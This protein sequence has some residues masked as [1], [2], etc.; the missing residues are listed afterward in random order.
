MRLLIYIY[1][2]VLDF[3]ITREF[4]NKINLFVLLFLSTIFA[5]GQT[6]TELSTQTKQTSSQTTISLQVPHRTC[7]SVDVLNQQL[8]ADPNLQQRRDAIEQQTAAYIA[9][10]PQSA[11][12][13]VI[14]IPVV[15]HVI[16]DGD[17]VGSN[18]NISIAAIMAQLDQL[19]EDFRKLNSDVGNVPS[20]FTSLVA[21]AEIEFCLAQRDP[22]GNATSGIM[23]HDL[24]QA[25]WTMN[26][27]DATVKPPTIWDRNQYLNIWTVVFGGGDASILGYAQFPGGGANTDGVVLRY[28]T[29]GSLTT[30]FPGGAP[31]D[32]G[33]T[34][35]HEVGHWLN[36]YHIW[37]DD[38]TACNGTD[39]VADTPNQADENYGCPTFP[40]ISCSNGP[41]GDLFMNYM[42]YVNDVC[43]YMFTE[44]QKARMQALFAPGGARASLTTSLGCL[45]PY[46]CDA[47]GGKLT[48]AD[49]TACVGAAALNFTPTAVNS[50]ANA[51]TAPS[52][53]LATT[54]PIFNRPLEDLSGLAT[55]PNGNEVYYNIFTFYVSSSGSYTFD[56][57]A[58]FDGFGIL[59]EGSFSA[60]APL[61]NVAAI[62][63]D[64]N[65]PSMNDPNFTVSLQTGQVY[66]L[67]TT[68]YSNV[69]TGTYSWTITP[70]AGAQLQDAPSCVIPT[71]GYNYTYFITNSSGNIIAQT[72]APVN[73]TG[74]PTGTY[75]VCGFSYPSTG[76]TMPATNGT[77]NLTT[78]AATLNGFAA[79]TCGSVSSDC[80]TVTINS[81]CCPTVT[82]P[83][84][85]TTAICHNAVAPSFPTITLSS[86][87]LGTDYTITWSPAAIVTTNSTCAP[88]TTTYTPTITC[89]AN[90]S[91][92]AGGGSFDVIV[93]PDPANFAVTVTAPAATC[94]SLPTVTVGSCATMTTNAVTTPAVTGCSSDADLTNNPVN[95]VYTHIQAALPAFTSDL[96][97]ATCSYPTPVS[98]TTAIVAC[99]VCAP[100]LSI[101]DPCNCSAGI[102]LDADPE[103]ELAQEVITIVPG[104]APYTVTVLTGG[105]VDASNV[106][107]TPATAT[108][109]ISGTTITAY[110][111][112]NGASTY[113]LTIQDANGLTDTI[114]GGTCTACPAC[115]ASQNMLWND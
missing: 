55:T 64:E 23:R 66:Y 33:R 71:I 115:A 35:T 5:W 95:G 77:V 113:S 72:N 61:S 48:D 103:N 34:G 50:T 106:A 47:C 100:T 80:I 27:V 98:G 99:D 43:M 88:I 7:G 62:D 75:T 93:Y 28:E 97:G 24:G 52:G 58:S 25:N 94:G 38:G 76:F 15:F 110:L 21:D 102:N 53:S 44:G 4:M 3:L 12:R 9:H 84:S 51:L 112:A 45:A 19:N 67:V 74:T 54:D 30:P 31:Y 83:A 39:D 78:W 73:M 1:I 22:S 59:Y 17:A 87:V 60:A 16:H 49:I 13:A 2:Y 11:E 92:I 65:Y 26:E 79:A 109:L 104:T 41:N 68:S 108:A 89:L 63:D 96:T 40:Q 46:T 91:V 69:Q 20:V 10:H 56:N 36:L 82:T 37:G 57:T 29:V 107:L 111:P 32:K 42:D 114:T 105:L 8:A 85:G 14:T 81:G 70:P 18:E 86:G 90:N 101:T 6:K